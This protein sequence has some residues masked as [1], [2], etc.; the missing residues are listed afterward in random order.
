M[1]LLCRKLCSCSLG[2]F[3]I[4]FLVFAWYTKSMLL[5]FQ[6]VNRQT[7]DSAKFVDREKFQSRSLV[8]SH[9]NLVL[10]SV[11]FVL[12][13]HKFVDKGTF[14][15][16]GC[17]QDP[18][19]FSRNRKRHRSA[20]PRSLLSPSELQEMPGDPVYLP[21]S[22]SSRR[23]LLPALA[24]SPDIP[25]K[26]GIFCYTYTQIHAVVLCPFTVFNFPAKK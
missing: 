1:F 15:W 19:L 22:G 23:R 6:N 9:Q 12:F 13:H 26:H 8:K 11:Q 7:P 3:A 18:F 10:I 14:I 25:P 20:V 4:R 21:A 2:L 5:P 17:G 16:C 24:G